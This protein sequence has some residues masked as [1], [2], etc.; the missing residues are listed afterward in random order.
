MSAGEQTVATHPSFDAHRA[1]DNGEFRVYFQPQIDLRS[2]QLTGAEALVR[3]SGPD[4]L[5]SPASFMTELEQAESLLPLLQLVANSTS[6][7]M[8]RWLRRAPG[9]EVA[10]NSSAAELDD[11]DL[12]A[13]M[14]DVLDMWRVDPAHL[15]LEIAAPGLAADM[16]RSRRTLWQLRELGIRVSIDN[17]GIEHLAM[18]ELHEL[19]IDELKIDRSLTRAVL[20]DKSV[21]EQISS[22]VHRAHAAGRNI[23]AEGIESEEVQACLQGLDCDI[24]QGFLYGQPLTGHEFE[25]CWLIEHAA[26]AATERSHD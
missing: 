1:I 7:E 2:Q 8:S 26:T 6:R 24:G 25:R 20:D 22:A 15:K 12:V 16:E 14:A 3:W 19:P 4:G 9:M 13:V 21:C 10:I 18:A 11:T 5:V 17:L 23:V